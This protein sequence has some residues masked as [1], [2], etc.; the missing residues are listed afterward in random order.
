MNLRFLYRGAS[1]PEKFQNKD[2]AKKEIM[3]NVLHLPK[4]LRFSVATIDRERK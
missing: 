3:S 1:Q 2:V 4:W